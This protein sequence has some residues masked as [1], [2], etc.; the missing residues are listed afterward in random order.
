MVHCS[1]YNNKPTDIKSNNFK[2]LIADAIR[3]LVLRDWDEI[4]K[5]NQYEEINYGIKEYFTD[6]T[7]WDN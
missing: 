3:D 6:I 5:I 2:N 1:I 7:I 4:V